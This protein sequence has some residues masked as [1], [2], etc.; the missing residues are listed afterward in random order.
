MA[1]LEVPYTIKIKVETEIVRPGMELLWNPPLAVLLAAFLVHAGLAG[2]S[3]A[4]YA[5]V[6]GLAFM[7]LT[8]RYAIRRRQLRLAEVAAR[9]ADTNAAGTVKERVGLIS[10][11][12]ALDI[13]GLPRVYGYDGPVCP[14]S[15]VARIQAIENVRSRSR[16]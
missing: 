2:P 7:T 11:D 8:T 3:P 16:Q 13:A 9:A 14:E 15:L 4:L 5:A 6:A 1:R 12:R 10:I